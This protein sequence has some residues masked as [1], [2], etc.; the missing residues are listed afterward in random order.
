MATAELGLAPGTGRSEVRLRVSP[1]R[2]SGS[3][4][5]V[6]KTSRTKQLGED[7]QELPERVKSRLAAVRCGS[8][9]PSAAAVRQE[10][11]NFASQSGDLSR[12]SVDQP[13]QAHDAFCL[14]PKGRALSPPCAMR[15]LRRCPGR[16]RARCRRRL[17]SSLSAAEHQCWLYPSKLPN[18]VGYGIQARC[19][20]APRSL[21]LSPRLRF[22]QSTSSAR[23]WLSHV[24]VAVSPSS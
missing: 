12:P 20:V 13:P 7:R 3:H 11:N 10:Q 19:L 9:W 18:F 5:S 16:G 23:I 2:T 6:D 15:D 21:K 14:H 17:C 24:G 1:G 8:I 4:R 22:A